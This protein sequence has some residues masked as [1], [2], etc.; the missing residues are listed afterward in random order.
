MGQHKNAFTMSPESE[1]QGSLPGSAPLQDEKRI[2]GSLQ[3]FQK[4]E[5]LTAGIST[6][7]VSCPFTSGFIQVS[8]FCS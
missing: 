8:A 5:K 6:I 2:C 3:A 7:P 1:S 4:L